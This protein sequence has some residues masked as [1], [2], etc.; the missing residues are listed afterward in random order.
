MPS[1]YIVLKLQKGGENI[2][3]AKTNIIKNNI[4]PIFDHEEKINTKEHDTIKIYCYDHHTMRKD[5][6]LGKLKMSV[7]K[8]T[9]S[10]KWNKMFLSSNK[11]H[12]NN[13]EKE[14]KK[15]KEK[16]LKNFSQ[17]IEVE[18]SFKKE[19]LKINNVNN[20]NNKN[21][22]QN[23][24]PT[25]TKNNEETEEIKILEKERN[26]RIEDEYHIGELKIEMF[27]ASYFIVVHRLSQENHI[28]QRFIKSDLN[29]NEISKLKSDFCVFKQL[30]HLPLQMI[31]TFENDLFLDFIIQLNVPL[32]SCIDVLENCL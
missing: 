14:E 22:F 5:V 18:I 13:D 3:V 29:F 16:I 31:H 6:L 15:E 10:T 11:K 17:Q 1:V 4:N 2:K 21:N 27:P 12:K 9:E 23:N 32:S 20:N 19:D 30:T 28:L 24:N 25:N 26:W 7:E 8:I